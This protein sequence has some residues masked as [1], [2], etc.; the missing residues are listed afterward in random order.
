MQTQHDQHQ[1]YHCYGSFIRHEGS[2]QLWRI[3]FCSSRVTKPT[4][5]HDITF[6]MAQNGPSREPQIGTNLTSSDISAHLKNK[7]VHYG[8]VYETHINKTHDYALWG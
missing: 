4:D 8:S 5:L 6:F 3:C 2:F 7:S 1:S